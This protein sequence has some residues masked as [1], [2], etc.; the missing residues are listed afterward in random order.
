MK[1]ILLALGL[2]AVIVSCE[3]KQEATVTTPDGK[4]TT[5][6]APTVDQS[7]VDAAKADANKAVQSATDA[8]KSITIPGTK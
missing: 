5:V 4:T 8:A 2:V 1:K 6:T 3:Q 7:K